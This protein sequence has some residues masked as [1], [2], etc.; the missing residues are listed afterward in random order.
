[1]TIE[2]KSQHEGST[3][4]KIYFLILLACMILS[5]CAAG[6]RTSSIRTPSSESAHELK[7]A[8][9]IHTEEEKKS[10]DVFT[11]I[12]AITQSTDN[13]QSVLPQIEALYLT[14]KVH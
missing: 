8:V 13:R 10:L 3:V 12:L 6:H 1:M 14:H 5:A 4:K 11:Q 7:E 2:S 9:P